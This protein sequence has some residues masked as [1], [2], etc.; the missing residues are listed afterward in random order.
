M[1]SIAEKIISGRKFFYLVKSV[2]L[3]DGKVKNLY[4]F[5]GGKKP[6]KIPQAK[7]Y[8]QKKEEEANCNWAVK[9]YSRDKII[10]DSE[11]R[12][13]EAMRLGYKNILRK[14]TE[15]QRKDLFDRFTLNF[16]YESN[17]IEGNSL[18]LKDV[19][20]V[21]FENA[22]IRGKSLREI[23]ETRNSRQAVDL[24]LRKKLSISHESIIKIQ[25]ILV[26]DVDTAIGYKK[27]PNF[28]MGRNVETTPPEKVHEEM[29]NLIKWYNYNRE[30][31][32]PL[33]LASVFHGR[34]EKIHPFEDGNGRVGRFLINAILINA[35]YPPLIIRRTVRTAYMSCLSAFDNGHQDNLK[36]FLLE[37]FKDTYRK[38]FEIYVKYV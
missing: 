36:R 11:I 30:K 32:H 27:I 35:G 3:P 37:K 7:D 26:K 20:I 22:A 28:I 2:R 19:A 16:T 14:L 13:I 29:E 6:K 33:V 31:T 4:K 25:K 1:V 10:N 24:L 34:F 21:I 23:Y 18:T 15:K 5:L 17:A 12:K 8:F 38:F 9:K